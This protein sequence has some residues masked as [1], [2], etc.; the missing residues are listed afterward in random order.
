MET[1]LFEIKNF[2]YQYPPF[3]KLPETAVDE[4]VTHIEIVY[5]KS[6]SD[7]LTKGQ[8]NTHL[9]FI[10]S[11]S[12]EITR[13]SGDFYNQ[14]GEGDMFGQFALLQKK[15]VRYPAKAVEDSLIYKIPEDIFN[16]LCDRF[17]HFGDF[18]VEDSGSRLRTA[19]NRPKHGVDNPLL[20]TPVEKLVHQKPVTAPSDISIQQ[21]AVDMTRARISSLILMDDGNITGILTDR[22]LRRR[23]VAKGVSLDRPVSRIMTTQVETVKADDYAFEA[24]LAMISH[25]V[26]HL[27]VL[28]KGK[29]V[30]VISASDIIQYESHGSIFLV[31]KISKQQDV[32][33]LVQL[34]RQV[35]KTFMHMVHEG[36]NSHMIGS[37]LS[38]IGLGISQRLLQLA[39]KK[40]GPPP[41]PYCY[42][43][44]GSMARD[45][46]VI[47]TD[48]DNAFILSD[49]YAPSL[50]DDYF[51]TLAA[52][53]SNGLADCGYP[54][55]KGDIMGTNPQWRVPLKEWKSCFGDWIENPQPQALLNASI[56]FDF[57]GVSGD[58]TLAGK[59]TDHIREIVPGH[60]RFLSCL[61]ANA[62]SRKPPL[63]FFRRF[64]LESD[65]EHKDTFNLKRRG[66]API[67]DMIRVHSLACGCQA[68][69]TFERLEDAD[70]ADLL[71]RGVKKEI[72]D[73]LEFISI[74][75]IRNQARQMEEGKA[76]DNSLKPDDLS[77][78]ERR[79]LK[80]AFLVIKSQQAYMRMKHK[81]TGQMIQP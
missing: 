35:P 54:Y 7:I 41:V 16:S 48:Q 24:M 21:A 12:V 31:D 49:N 65:G 13:S 10:R 63:G 37:A 23:A 9:F 34:S 18:M 73:A 11:G 39:E 44:M 26:H 70:A 36:A 67:S 68:L 28:K 80:D 81:H 25:N 52:F 20:T 58:L 45:E 56:F 4:L 6:G 14:I 1:E 47:V 38:G 22:D 8:M 69:N 75:R 30:G 32:A 3:R 43:T 55:C 33:G 29:P 5:F 79:H 57:K 59:L 42:I 71:P 53:V 15:P 19:I 51:K 50:H 78:F 72:K 77:K 2:I 17:D 64:V 40:L 46:Q 76:P 27:P 62:L 60:P 74:T 61:A 66:I